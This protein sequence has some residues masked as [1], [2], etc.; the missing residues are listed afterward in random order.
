MTAGWRPL[1]VKLRGRQI[2]IRFGIIHA[3]ETNK[4]KNSD[5]DKM[6]SFSVTISHRNRSIMLFR[7]SFSL[8]QLYF[9]IY[10]SH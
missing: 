8:S 7:R 3:V 10:T 5:I 4:K 1:Y 2:D 9:T 6:S